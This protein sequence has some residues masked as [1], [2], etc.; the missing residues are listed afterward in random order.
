MVSA[1]FPGKAWALL[2]ALGAGEPP[3][4]TRDSTVFSVDGRGGGVFAAFAGNFLVAPGVE[5]ALEGGPEA[6]GFSVDGRGDLSVGFPGT[7]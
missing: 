2:V 1:A 6:T 3:E 5:T 4:E 7:V